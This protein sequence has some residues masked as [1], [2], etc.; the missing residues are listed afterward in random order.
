MRSRRVETKLNSD[1]LKSS[2]TTSIQF[3]LQLLKQLSPLKKIKNSFFKFMM[4][5]MELLCK[6]FP[7]KISSVNM[8]LRCTR[9]S[10]P[11]TK[12]LQKACKIQRK[13]IADQSKSQERKR[14]MA[15]ASSL[16]Y[17]T[18]H[19][20]LPKKLLFTLLSVRTKEPNSSQFTRVNAENQPQEMV[21]IITLYT[22]IL[23]LWLT[24]RTPKQLSSKC[25]STT[26]MATMDWLDHALPNTSPLLKPQVER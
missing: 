7:S 12:L 18:Y 14:K 4:L 23:I 8:N 25:T 3:G 26:Q 21:S 15:G 1:K 2:R 22:Q 9:L 17:L 20:V 5:M 24:L 13:R 16:A 6:I 19:V 10:L 11:E